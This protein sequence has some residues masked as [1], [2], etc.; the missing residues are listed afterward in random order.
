MSTATTTSTEKKKVVT[1]TNP[2]TDKKAIEKL[3][4][5]RIG[6]LLKAPFFGNLAT[7]LIIK[8]ADE[9]L[10]TAAT[11]GRYFYYNSEFVDKLSIK[12]TEFLFGHETLH[13][14]YDHMGRRNDR[15][16]KLFNIAADYCVNADLINQRIGDKITTVPILY[17]RKYDNM[18]AEEVY[19]I[20]YK[21]AEK[22]DIS[23][24]LDK[25]LDEHLDDSTEGEDEEGSGR[26]KLSDEEKKAI[27]D[28]MIEAVIS[29][30]QTVSKENIPGNI[31]R[32]I[33]D[34]TEPKM[35]WREILQ[36][37]FKSTIKADYTWMRP[38]RKSW[39]LDAILPAQNNATRI[40][41]AISID[42]SGSMQPEMLRD[43]LSEV[44]GITEEFD[45]YKIYLW[46][47]DTEVYNY[48][49]FTPDNVH[50]L[51]SYEIMGNGGNAF[52]ENWRFMREIELEPELFIMFTD[53]YPCPHW[54]MPGDE[55][56]CETMFLLHSTTTIVAPF[57]ETIYY[58]E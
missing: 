8:N 29:A 30:A 35:N 26:P 54:C 47:I 13:N 46:C 11:D 44:K 19:D 21:N 34:V 52:E 43:F 55:D 36:Q 42:S 48:Q 45:D 10:S 6:L 51:L 37:K 3:I 50:E 49:V 57:G 18:S 15:D 4:T 31:K 17:D 2:T 27:R 23:G 40:E 25:L 7:R 5:A 58:H 12:E 24:L 38:S 1:V 32:W 39:H 22:I 16:P 33:Q 14:V 9:W 20:L 41:V 28:E 56:Y 53:G